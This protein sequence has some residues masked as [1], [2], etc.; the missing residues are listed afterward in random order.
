[1]RLVKFGG[2]IVLCLS[3]YYGL[4][5]GYV[6][7]EFGTAFDDKYET[8]YSQIKQV[9][10]GRVVEGRTFDR[11]MSVGLWTDVSPV[12][13]VKSS[14]YVQYQ[15]GLA[16]RRIDRPYWYYMVGPAFITSPD[17][18]LGS[19]FQVGHEVGWGAVDSRGVRFGFYIKHFSDGGLSKRNEGRNFIG[20]RTGF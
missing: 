20:I 2:I 13:G 18:L 6:Y 12:S 3:L 14:G 7:S 19:H 11:T 16:T 9:E 1:M 5:Y 8:Q 17:L 10:I 4:S 15:I